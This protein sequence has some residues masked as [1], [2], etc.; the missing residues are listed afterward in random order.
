M[1]NTRYRLSFGGSILG[2]DFR[3]AFIGENGLS[4]DGQTPI[5]GA[6]T[7]F[8]EPGGVGYVT[9]FLVR[10]RPA[11][12]AQRTVTY[13]P[14]VDGILPELGQSALTEDR[15][16]SALYN[17]A[18]SPGTALGFLSD[19]GQGTDGDLAVTGT[20]IID[21]GDTPNNFL[22]NP[23]TVFDKNPNDDQLNNTLPGGL[24]LWDSLEHSE[25]QLQSL[26]VS[27]AATLRVI[28][29]NPLMLRVQGLVQVNGIIDV[30]GEDGQ[31]AGGAVASG[32]AGGA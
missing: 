26:T 32:G 23:F 3:K 4:G 17:P 31:T 22:G 28:G 20:V 27:S 13:D 19:F 29:V 12:N 2:L 6:G 9:E 18:T 15:Y 10:D 16:N 5:P 7:V 25:L 8:P 30:A 14:L 24:L 11:I 1:D 21:T